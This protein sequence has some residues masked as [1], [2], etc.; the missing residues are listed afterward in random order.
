MES[1]FEVL[2]DDTRNGLYVQFPQCAKATSAVNQ[3]VLSVSHLLDFDGIDE[4][5]AFDTVSQFKDTV[6]LL[7]RLKF[8]PRLSGR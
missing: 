8:N 2:L 7:A 5:V 4:A 3:Q 6:E 1:F